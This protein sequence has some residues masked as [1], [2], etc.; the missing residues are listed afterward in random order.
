M[1]DLFG[2]SMNYIM[3]G[4]LVVLGVAL[5]SV[6]YV[7]LRNRAKNLGVSISAVLREAVVDLL[8]A[9]LDRLQMVPSVDHMWND[10]ARYWV[11]KKEKDDALE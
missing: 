2:L 4:L 9:K 1:D 7:A 10:P 6:A 5:A 3:L 11:G 8:E